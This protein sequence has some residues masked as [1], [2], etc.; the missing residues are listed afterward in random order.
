M[1]TE[2]KKII[3]DAIR[4]T[5]D[6]IEGIYKTQGIKYRDR[7]EEDIGFDSLD[8]VEFFMSIEDR[9]NIRIPSRIYNSLT[10]LKEI[11]KFIYSPEKYIERQIRINPNH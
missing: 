7:L 6:G 3:L 10:T 9:A 8:R 4:D 2:T 11:G 5:T 1:T